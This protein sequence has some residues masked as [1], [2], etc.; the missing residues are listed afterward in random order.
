MEF[1]RGK[2]TKVSE[3]KIAVAK[4]PRWW[5]NIQLGRTANM[6][7]WKIKQIWESENQAY[8]VCINE[9]ELITVIYETFLYQ[10]VSLFYC[11]VGQED[12]DLGGCK[13]F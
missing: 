1:F 6:D 2:E 11:R 8:W 4:Q 3:N 13:P 9:N 12:D 7:H 10:N 5:L